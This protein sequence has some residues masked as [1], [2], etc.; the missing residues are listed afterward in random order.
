MSLSWSLACKEPWQETLFPD[1]NPGEDFRFS[2]LIHAVVGI[3]QIGD[4]QVGFGLHV[5]FSLMMLLVAIHWK[6]GLP[7]LALASWVPT[8]WRGP[9]SSRKG[10]TDS[11]C[12]A[13]GS[14]RVKNRI[15]FCGWACVL[16]TPPQNCSVQN[17]AGTYS[18][19]KG[20]S[21]PFLLWVMCWV[22]F[23]F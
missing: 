7:A 4:V 20:N 2:V 12:H 1:P 21:P 8:L 11:M 17:L 14:G 16:I 18:K 19:G 10:S 15:S 9:S 5:W 23:F 6:A 22:F 13:G 3:L